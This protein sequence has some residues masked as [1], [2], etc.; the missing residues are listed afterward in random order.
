MIA[1]LLKDVLL[2]NQRSFDLT[3]FMSP[4][5]FCFDKGA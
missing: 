4:V 2:N 3:D 5:R 1:L